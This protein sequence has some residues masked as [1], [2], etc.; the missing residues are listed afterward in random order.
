MARD[1]QN[2]ND[3]IEEWADLLV[4]ELYRLRELYNNPD[5]YNE[6]SNPIQFLL[7]RE[8]SM[9]AKFYLQIIEY[10]IQFW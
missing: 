6:L 5:E 2:W 4:E 3:S 8:S 10:F 1:D 9:N 7:Q